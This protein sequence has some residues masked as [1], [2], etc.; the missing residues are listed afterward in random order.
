MRRLW[1][2]AALAFVLDQASKYWIFFGLDLET[3]Q[4]I[5][6]LP[7]YL[8]LLKGMNTGIN[9]GLFSGGEAH[10]RYILIG[11]AV[12]ISLALVV[13]AWRSFSRPIEFVAAGLVVGGA[14]GNAMDRVLHPGVLDFL[15]MSCCGIVNPFVFNVADVFIFAGA[16]GLALF[17][18]GE[19][20]P[21]RRKKS[22]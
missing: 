19:A 10:Q 16:F 21:P 3:I 1:L 13:W 4:R 17:T 18:G 12:A 7:P 22:A 6:V 2:T 11:I 8:V 9:F 15:N 5:E 14:L 20:K